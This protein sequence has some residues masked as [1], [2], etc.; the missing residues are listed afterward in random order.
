[1]IKNY[2]LIAWRN[3][4][5]SPFYSTVNILGLS[6]GITFALLIGNN[7]WREFH[8]NDNL[9]NA[10]RQHIIISNWKDKNE[11]VELATLGPLAKALK[12]NYP[13][14][15]SNYYRYDGVTS[16]VSAGDKN[17]REGIQIGDS[18]LLVMYGFKLMYGNEETALNQPFTIVISKEKALKY[19]GETDVLG[20]AL[21]IENFSGERHDFKI[22]GILEKVE[23]NSVT[24][25]VDDYAN[26]LF[27]SELNLNY[28]G[29][30][31]DWGNA[32][33]AEYVELQENVSPQQL[34]KPISQLLS[35]HAPQFAEKMTPTVLPLK[36]YYRSANDGLVAKMIFGLSAIA[37][38]ILLM[39]EINFI[40]MNISRSSTRMREI[41]V[42][43]VL[44]G[45][46]IQLI[47]QF[48]TES[49]LVVFISFLL[50]IL[51]YFLSMK[52][53]STI[54][55]YPLISLLDL[56]LSFAIYAFIGALLLG[57]VSGI[58]PAFVLSSFK[59]V[60]SLKGS[61]SSI[62]DKV[63][64]RKS[65]VGFQFGMATLAFVGAIIISQQLELFF[66]NNIGYDKEA[67]VSAQV[68]R[69]WSTTGVNK[70]IDIR[71]QFANSSDVKEVSLSFEIPNGNNG[72]TAQL[73]RAD[74][75]S[76][77]VIAAQALRTDENF[78]SVYQ[79]PISE[80]EFFRGNGLDSAK[81]ILNQT[82]VNAMGWSSPT[83]A[84]GQQIRIP[85]DPTF[86]VI[87]GV[88]NDFHFGSMQHKVSPIIFFNVEF[89][90]I[91]RFLNFKL[92]SGNIQAHTEA[93][94]KKWLELFPDTPFE[95]KFMD[96]SLAKM[97][98]TEI[99]LKKA[100]LLACF[101]ALIIVLF[102]VIGLVSLSI[103]K[104]TKEIGIRKV[105]GSKVIAILVLFIKEFVF[106]ILLASVFVSPFIYFVMYKWLQQYA[107]RIEI[108]A[109]PFLF[110]IFLLTGIT[111][112]II[113]LQTYKTALANPAK[114]LK[115]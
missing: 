67:I 109:Y 86:F 101:L 46:K 72:G 57:L 108:T 113:G 58:Y 27:V 6:I 11:G 36:A 45:H 90:P 110:S 30:N 39:A 74:S 52:S 95:Y 61:Q 71:K 42:R 38:F 37:I 96:E 73:Y 32:Y 23:K 12:E 59:A 16:G 40:N 112:I 64:F 7:V 18:T 75:D 56:P 76:T 4:L 102:G 79:I 51:F 60:D 21:S 107:Y 47:Y 20:R 41:G 115:R 105:L 77:Q 35:L 62:K 1:M 17:F 63:W 44:G 14:L 22:T 48:I 53:F 114:S 13:A 66:S 54:I 83:E 103:Q 19:F 97:Y 89:S 99:Q 92:S 111:S 93:L 25:L 88:V 104:R 98:K 3:L 5:K 91:Y 34:E 31:M 65:L 68:P 49:F 33:I 87:Q 55:G 82:A 2:F 80:G 106:V 28:F 94:Q 43:K 100:S 50:A 10:D 81:V 8:V 78:L 29:R 15:V 70:M 69:D 85:G 9:K 84:I 26:E 24:G